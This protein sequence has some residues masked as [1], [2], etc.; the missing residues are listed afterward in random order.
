MGAKK[1]ISRILGT[2]IKE[3]THHQGTDFYHETLKVSHQRFIGIFVTVFL[4][5]NA[6]FGAIYYLVPGTIT[7]THQPNYLDCFSFSVQ[8]MG[9][10]GYGTFYPTSVLAHVLVTIEV[11]IGLVG[12]GTFAALAFARISLPSSKLI[13]SNKMVIND[14]E[15][16][17]NLMF[18]VAHLRQNMI[19]DAHISLQLLSTV[20]NWTGQIEMVMVPLELTKEY[21]HVLTGGWLIKH[22]ISEDSPIYGKTSLDLHQQH[23]SLIATITGTDGTTSEA[24]NYVYS[25]TPDDII[26]NQRFKSIIQVD[27]V[28]GDHIVDLTGI[29]EMESSKFSKKN[30]IDY[31]KNS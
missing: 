18:R 21:Y 11:M 22:R 4:S 23:A 24:V 29:N 20:K 3:A 17:P 6:F 26:W 2:G 30:K 15:G 1:R 16:E 10:V 13:V 9:T 5:L 31:P 25:Y 27:P 19:V 8:T 14:D 28:S 7:G 12:I